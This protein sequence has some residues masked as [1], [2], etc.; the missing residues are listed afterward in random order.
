MSKYY[1]FR[2]LSSDEYRGWQNYWWISKPESEKINYF[3]KKALEEGW[4]LVGG[5]RIDEK[6]IYTQSVA[7]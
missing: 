4:N 5:I 1:E 6:G 2:T 7:K 3:I